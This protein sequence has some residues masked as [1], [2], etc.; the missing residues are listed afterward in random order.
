MKIIFS[1]KGFD[2][3]YGG[4]PSPI[5]DGEPISLP[6][7]YTKNSTTTYE[8]IGLG[9]VV[10]DLSRGKI[11]ANSTCHADPDLS[12][13]A[14]GQV[15][16]A[17]T[18]LRNQQVG[19]NDL[20]LFF[21]RFR[22]AE[23]KLGKYVWIKK[24]KP[25]HRIFGWLHIGKIIRLADD[26]SDSIRLNPNLAGHPHLRGRW[27]DN[28]TLYLCS[29]F[30]DL[31]TGEKYPGFGKFSASKITK[32]TECSVA[33]QISIW[34]C[35]DWLNP[36]LGGCGMSYHKTSSYSEKFVKSASIGQ[37]FV[38]SPHPSQEVRY[39]IKI[40]FGNALRN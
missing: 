2:T 39:W 26:K 40:L 20:F 8:E 19:I 14:F 21:G 23:K 5:I 6:I 22:E 17:Q 15:G 11:C 18:H 38:S 34:K 29:D 25:H 32:L 12:V 3:K 4:I 13:G 27:P 33:N 30:C 31:G 7:P 28:N 1:R 36:V 35:P 9:Q 10:S 24:S 37:E 16:A